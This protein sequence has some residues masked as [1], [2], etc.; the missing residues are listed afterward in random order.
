MLLLTE[1]RPAFVE[2]H[3]SARIVR[4]SLLVRLQ[5][6]LGLVI[7]ERSLRF[8]WLGELGQLVDRAQI[9]LIVG[10]V[11]A[12]VVALAAEQILLVRLGRSLNNVHQALSLRHLLRA[13]WFQRNSLVSQ[14]EYQVI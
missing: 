6:L 12:A 8:R 7:G 5:S 1:R 11:L 2:V 9:T 13:C 3:T 10:L 14:G 4:L